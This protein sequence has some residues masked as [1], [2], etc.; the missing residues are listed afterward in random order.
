MSN[1]VSVAQQAAELVQDRQLRAHLK[2]AH[3]MDVD[4]RRVV[5]KMRGQ[6]SECD[7]KFVAVVASKLS[8][9]APLSVEMIFGD[10]E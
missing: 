4:S 2:S 7:V 10:D 1:Y 9:E 5:R 8:Q 6:C 3:G